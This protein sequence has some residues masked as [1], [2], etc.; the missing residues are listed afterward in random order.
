MLTLPLASEIAAPGMVRGSGLFQQQLILSGLAHDLRQPL[1]VIEVCID[2]LDLVLPECE[3]G[4]RQQLELL[5]QQVDNA[6][7]LIC[8]ALRQWKVT[9]PASRS[10]TNV[11]SAAVTY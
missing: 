6:N 7:R 8:E 5:R 1:S 3:P 9:A 2:Y 11:E 10:S 4:T